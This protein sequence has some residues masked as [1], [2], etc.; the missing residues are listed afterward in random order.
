MDWIENIFNWINNFWLW[1]SSWLSSFY[2]IISNFFLSV[3]NVLWYI[4]SIFQTLRY[5]LTTLLSS[6]YDTLI[7]VFD[8]S[9]FSYLYNWFNDLAWLIWLW[10]ALFISSLLFVAFV[11]IIIAFVLRMFRLNA[12][13]RPLQKKLK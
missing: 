5:W 4:W 6:V 12:D 9:L 2:S 3:W 8:T 11:R 13:Y 10:G 7:K 1:L